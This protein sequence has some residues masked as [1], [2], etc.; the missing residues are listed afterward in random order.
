M[1]GSRVPL[2]AWVRPPFAVY[3]NGILQVEG[4]DYVVRDDVLH[5]P[6]ELR[7][8][9]VSGR[10]W[11]LGAFGVGT[12]R[13]DDSVDVRCERGGRPALAEGLAILP[14]PS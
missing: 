8:D 6:G 14:D 12:Y 3:L 10:R 5:F 7:K 4:S 2:P 13:Q 9:R 11:L 1:P